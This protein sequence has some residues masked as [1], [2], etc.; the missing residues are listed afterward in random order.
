MEV[1]ETPHDSNNE[2]RMSSLDDLPK[3]AKKIYEAAKKFFEEAQ[4]LPK[5]QQ[6]FIL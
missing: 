2:R 3:A 5:Q 6:E 4:S 1:E